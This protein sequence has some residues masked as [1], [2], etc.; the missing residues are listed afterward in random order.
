MMSRTH[1]Y[2]IANL[3]SEFLDGTKVDVSAVGLTS[4]QERVWGGLGAG[5]ANNWDGDKY[6]LYG[7]GI[8]TTSL[9]SFGESYSLKGN[10][11]F[12]VKW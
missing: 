9:N 7:E 5:G 10:V 3:Y 2:G 8:M 12:R 1:L 6:S 11:G 4:E